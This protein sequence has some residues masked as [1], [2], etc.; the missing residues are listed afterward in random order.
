MKTRCASALGLASC[1]LL[2]RL[3]AAAPSSPPDTPEGRRVRALLA[4]FDAGRPDALRAFVSANFAASAL[5]EVPLEQRVQRLGN[6]AQQA[7]PLEF[8]R[9][10]RESGTEIAFLARSKKS[11]QWVE[12]GV[13]LEPGP[14][15]GILGLLFQPSDGPAAAHPAKAGSDAEAAAAAHALLQ[16][17]AAAGEFSGVA[18]IAHDGRPI[19]QEA[20]GLADRA[21]SVPNQTDTRFNVGS[22]GKA[23]TQVAIAQLAAQGKIA[24]TDTIRK[25]L[26]DYPSPAADRI[27]IQQLVTMTSGLGDVFGEK[28]DATPKDRLRTLA[29]YLPLFAGEPLLFEPGAGRSYSNAGYV[30]LGLI[31]EKVSGESYSDYVRD[32]VFTPAGMTDTG[33]WPQDA[34]VPNRA[35]GYTRERGG[36]REPGAEPGGRPE[37]ERPN[38]YALPARAS[39][40]GGAYSTAL[41]LLRFDQALRGDRLLSREYGDWFFSGKAN[42]PA[43]GVRAAASRP[44]RAGGFGIAGGTAGANAVL[45]TDLDTGYTI[46]VLSNLDPPSA[47]SLG[48]L[49]RELLGLK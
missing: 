39:S 42:P 41:D 19:F 23:F 21:F 3:L 48:R 9:I 10:V 11:G 34:V 12:V 40:A 43:A 28:Y 49:L 2:A 32:H 1:L 30:V 14:P 47:E 26:P 27:T 37:T 33:D 8:D 6:M 24:F 5:A 7:G 4:A 46:V 45:E 13:R 25:H 31:V 16:A 22:I 38:L 17:R 29:D 35:V 44:A 36:D 20:V 18:L 15:R